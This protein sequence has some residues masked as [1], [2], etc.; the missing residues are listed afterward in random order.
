MTGEALIT[1]TGNLGSDPEIRITPNGQNVCSFSVANTPRIKK[2]EEWQD[3]ETLWLRCFV[4][5]NNATGAVNELRKGS[6]VV[7]TGRL[8]VA[9]WTDSNGAERNSFEVNVDG[10]GLVP[11]NV[12]DPV[13][14]PVTPREDDFPW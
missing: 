1:V 4:W 12:T 14:P 9:K 7:I 11:K 6:R 3:G 13:I 10:Y 2:N 8:S 5:G